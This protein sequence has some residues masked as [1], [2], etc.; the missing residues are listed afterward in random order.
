MSYGGESWPRIYLRCLSLIYS[1]LRSLASILTL[2]RCRN[3]HCKHTLYL[4]RPS[5]KNLRGEKRI[6][7]IA[8]GSNSLINGPLRTSVVA[9]TA[10]VLPIIWLPVTLYE[11][12][13]KV[14]PEECSVVK[15]PKSVWERHSSFRPRGF[16]L[17]LTLVKQ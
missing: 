8:D 12:D 17:H 11:L 14:I 10:L 15:R 13:A 7:R 3:V 1:P 4:E 2:S 9:P 5:K 6:V 16:K